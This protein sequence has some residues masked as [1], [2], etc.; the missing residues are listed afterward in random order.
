MPEFAQ[1]FTV[2]SSSLVSE[3][4]HLAEFA[5]RVDSM[6]LQINSTES[7]NRVCKELINAWTDSV[8]AHGVGRATE[9]FASL[10][11]E[12]QSNSGDHLIKTG[13]GGVVIET[14]EHPHVEK[15]LV[16]EQGGYLALEKHE[17]KEETLFV[18]EGAG[19]ILHRADSRSPLSLEVLKDGKEIYLAP[20][21]EHCVIGVQD[22]L[23]FEISEDYKGMDQDLIF[24]YEPA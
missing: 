19:L 8:P 10:L 22:L 16:I 24:L 6:D 5:R 4:I 9:T 21:M 18:R 2:D 15:Y 3:G 1:H 11:A 7:F 14:H 13:W 17:R 23:L 12:L 20:G